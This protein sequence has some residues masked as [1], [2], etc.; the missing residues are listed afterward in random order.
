MRS[1]VQTTRRDGRIDESGAGSGSVGFQSQ[2]TVRA[3][4]WANGDGDDVNG[5][6]VW[7]RNQGGGGVEEERE[8][9]AGQPSR[10][11]RGKNHEKQESRGENEPF[12]WQSSLRNGGSQMT[13]V[14][15]PF[16]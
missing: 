4:K 3:A 2:R 9:R 1:P 6:S 11:R 13:R 10:R 15:V 16:R 12:V 14:A 8:G 7:L 5:R